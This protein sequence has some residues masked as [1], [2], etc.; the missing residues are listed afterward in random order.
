MPCFR[1]RSAGLIALLA[2]AAPGC[3]AEPSTE[4]AEP[5]S[6]T[7]RDSANVRIALSTDSSWTVERAWT[8]AARPSLEIG[9]GAGAEFGR[10]VGAVRLGD[11]R[12]AVADGQTLDIRVFSA[13]GGLLERFGGRGSGPGEFRRLDNLARI[14]GDSL[15]GRND[16]LYRHEIYAA[17]GSYGR[18]VTAPPAGGQPAPV[19]GWWTAWTCSRSGCMPS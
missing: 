16:G 1:F 9:S 6:F 18:T 13:D 2:A 12:I 7:V 8:V 17:D 4:P 3:G 19:V 14:R 10:V 15:V 5:P 11:G